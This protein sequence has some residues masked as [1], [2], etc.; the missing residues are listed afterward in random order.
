MYVQRLYGAACAVK[1]RFVFVRVLFYTAAILFSLYKGCLKCVQI[2][3]NP[4]SIHFPK[5]N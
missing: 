3:L 5:S 4:I 2:L 1:E